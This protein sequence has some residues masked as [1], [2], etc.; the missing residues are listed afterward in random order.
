MTLGEVISEY[1]KEHNMSYR[2]FAEK[3]GLSR[4]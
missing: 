4:D 2:R 1:C 3:S